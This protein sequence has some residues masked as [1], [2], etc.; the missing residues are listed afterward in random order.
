MLVA[1]AKAYRE[2]GFD[3]LKGLDGISAAQIEEHLKAL[4]RIRQV[5]AL[6]AELARCGGAAR[7]RAP[8]P[9]SPS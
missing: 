4:R 9:S 2:Q 8:I 5:N 3:H 1:K 7:L 6:N